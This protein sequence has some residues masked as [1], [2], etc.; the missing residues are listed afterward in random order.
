M[1][2]KLIENWLINVHELGYQIPF[3][4]VLVSEKYTILHSQKGGRGEHGKDVVARD[5]SGQLFAFQLKGDDITL[6]RWRDEIRNQVEELVRLPVSV[7]VP[8]ISKEEPHIPVLV[9]NGEIVGDAPTSIEAFADTWEKDGSPRLKTWQRGQ[10]LSMFINAHGAY[11]PAELADFGQFVELYVSN[12]RE[13]L[14]RKKLAEFLAKSVSPSIAQGRSRKTKRAIESMILLGSY[15]I[16]PYERAGN[17]ISAAEGWTI[18][19]ATI[20]HVA[21][22]E[23]LPVKHYEPSLSLVWKA[24]D[25]NLHKLKLEVIERGHFVEPEHIIAETDFLRGVRTLITLGWVTATS[26]IRVLQDE[27]ETDSKEI[28][29]IVKK[30]LSTMRLSGEA[31]WPFVVCLSLYLGRRI[32]S[33]AAEGLLESWVRSII[34][35]NNGKEA[36]G[37]P[38][39]YWLQEKVM[40]FRYDLL[41]PYKAERF[42]EHS[43]TIHSALDMLVRRLCRQFVSSS[44]PQASRLTFCDYIPD[45]PS[46]WFLWRSRAGDLQLVV[47]EQPASWSEWSKRV[48]IVQQGSVPGILLKYPEWILPFVLT[49]PHRMNRFLSALIDGLIGG[50][51]SIV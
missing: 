14:P 17:H 27:E 51:C 33:S 50:R 39:P 2:E 36:E 35:A 49:Y 46:E 3:C 4:E 41:P 24:L 18:V 31:D 11:L 26:L 7:T 32:G 44:W 15:L 20:M 22:R 6:Q 5:S 48:S 10:L 38:P 47:P 30:N 23:N 1:I 9:T 21:Q 28:L 37:V 16:E 13:R 12:F 25:S 40:A 45:D 43:Y 42:D 8:S 19:A 34:G 29:D